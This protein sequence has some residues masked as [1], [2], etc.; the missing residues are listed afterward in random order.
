MQV[1]E[2]NVLD[3]LYLHLDREDEPWSVHL[4]VVAEGR[5]DEQRLRD[6]VRTAAAPQRWTGRARSCSA[7]HRRSTGTAR[8]SWF[9]RARARTTA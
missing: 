7:A 4:E 1:T 3:E 9:A 8:S 2:L 6:A 5:L